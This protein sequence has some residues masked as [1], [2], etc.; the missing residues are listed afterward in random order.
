MFVMSKCS[1]VMMVSPNDHVYPGL[2]LSLLHRNV[3]NSP[4]AISVTQEHPGSFNSSAAFFV[5]VAQLRVTTAKRSTVY[6]TSF[7]CQSP[8][9][10][11]VS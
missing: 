8:V 11:E 5:D 1:H 2:S 10:V 6:I 3:F 9:S 4:T 7:N